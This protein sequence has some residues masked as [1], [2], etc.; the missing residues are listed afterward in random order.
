MQPTKLI[1]RPKDT[2]FN[3]HR[4]KTVVSFKQAPGSELSHHF[5]SFDIHSCFLCSAINTI[6]QSEGFTAIGS[7]CDGGFADT[8]DGM[9]PVLPASSG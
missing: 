7:A 8:P 9:D 5:M 4:L 1:T 3:L 6:E 2:D